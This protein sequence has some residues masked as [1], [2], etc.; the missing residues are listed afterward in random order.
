MS[1]LAYR[2]VL[3][4][5]SGEA[6]MGEEDYGIDPKVINRLAHEVIEAQQ[7]G[8]EIALVIGGGNIFRGAGL[9][10]GGMDRVTGDQMGMLA[11]VINALAM[12]DALEKLGAKVRV[13]S[14]IKINDVCEDFIRRRAIRHLEKGRIAIFA[15]G[16]G[17]PF[18][19]TDSGAALRAIEI[20]ADLLLKATKVDGVYDKD[21]K[22]HADAVKYDS[23]T[24]DEVIIQ[25]LE[26]MDTAAF[27]LARDSDLPLR[28][29]DMGHP[30][31][32]LRIL[33]GEPI[34]TLVKGRS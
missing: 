3:L 18:F 32:L 4:K 19:T 31:V 28:I 27:A 23:L 6:L 20:G 12:Q 5:L 13:M 14:A 24:Y 9:A 17:N 11:T 2:R 26:V 15:A 34:G 21:P 33:R 30:G 10:A 1:E 7:A 16:T 8:A 25:G 22:K 29:F